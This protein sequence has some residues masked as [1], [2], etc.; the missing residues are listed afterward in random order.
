[1]KK[2]LNI[3]QIIFSVLLKDVNEDI[4]IDGLNF[5]NRKTERKSVLSFAT[6]ID[7]WEIIKNNASIS[8]VI[9]KPSD[10]LAYQHKEFGRKITFITDDSPEWAFYDIHDYVADNTDLY[11]VY[12][13]PKKIGNNC[14]IHS[15]AIIEDGVIIEADVMIG[16]HTTVRRGSVISKGAIIGNNTTI[17][18]EGFQIIRKENI[19]RHIRHYGGVFVGENVYIGNNTCICRSLFEGSTYIGNNAK[20]D[21][22][23]NIP[24]NAYIGCNAVITTGVIL[25]GSS[26]VKDNAWIGKNSTILNGV[27]IGEGALV[28]I[29][30]VVIRDV[31]SGATVAGNPARILEKNTP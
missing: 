5:C 19:S 13:F 20:I 26:I 29:G 16:S 18:A 24:H 31:P 12:D 9:V 27:V 30:S 10:L 1:M 6:S 28:G 25:C 2:L 7:Y 3:N 8:A 22:L 23:V 14:S 11:N 17:S 4:S 15:S 21:H